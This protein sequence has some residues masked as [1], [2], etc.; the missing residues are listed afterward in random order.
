MRRCGGACAWPATKIGNLSRS[1]TNR[2]RN[3]SLTPVDG[4]ATAFRIRRENENMLQFLQDPRRFFLPPSST[5]DR[6]DDEPARSSD[7]KV[8]YLAHLYRE[9]NPAGPDPGPA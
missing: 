8:S 9:W 6:S 3:L 7:E 4:D 2:G 5:P 1:Q